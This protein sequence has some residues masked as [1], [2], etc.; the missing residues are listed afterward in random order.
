M[1]TRSTVSKATF[2]ALINISNKTLIRQY[3]LTGFP[4]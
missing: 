3:G 1:Q 2:D 4:S